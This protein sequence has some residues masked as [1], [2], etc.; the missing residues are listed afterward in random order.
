MELTGSTLIIFCSLLGISPAAHKVRQRESRE[1]EVE[2]KRI[3]CLLFNV[4]YMDIVSIAIARVC[5]PCTESLLPS[6]ALCPELHNFHQ[7]GFTS[8]S[9][10]YCPLH[11]HRQLKSKQI[12]FFHIFIYLNDIK[13]NL[14]LKED[15]FP[16]EMRA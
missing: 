5:P 16:H 14:L 11:V 10:I 2:D 15:S 8:A 6:S 13:I 9:L 3:S 12:I 4:L 1:L 7:S